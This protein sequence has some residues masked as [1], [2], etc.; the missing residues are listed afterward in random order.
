MRSTVYLVVLL[1]LIMMLAA[2][3]EKTTTQSV[4]SAP[5]ISPES[6]T[7]ESGTEVTITSTDEDVKIYYTINGSDPTNTSSLYSIPLYIPTIFAIG[8]NTGVVKARAYKDG[9]EPS[10]ITEVNYA[11]NYAEQVATPVITP[12]ADSLVIGNTVT[13]TCGTPGSQIRYTLDGSEPTISSLI[14]SVPVSIMKQGQV[15]VKAIAL[16]ASMNPSNVAGKTYT[17]TYEAPPMVAVPAGTL[18]FNNSVISISGF[19][20]APYEVSKV[21]YAAVMGETPSYFTNN[22]NAPVE[23]VSWFDTVEYCNRRSMQEG[24]EPCYSY[25]TYGTNPDDWPADWDKSKSNHELVTCNFAMNGYR[26]PTEMEWMYAANAA[27]ADTLATP[28]SGGSTVG[29]VAWYISNSGN[30]THVVGT[31]AA[32]AL[33]IYDLSGNVWEWCWDIYGSYPTGA[34]NNPSGP[35]AGSYRIF[36]GGSWH[37]S[38]PNCRIDTRNW[39]GAPVQYYDL[40]FRVVRK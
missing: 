36:R 40:G 7:Y 28:Y 35:A 21:G 19:F 20:M 18:N 17:V 25:S 37:S 11:T 31:K 2:C 14:Y 34:Q 8:A 16:R 1:A 9:Y 29:N 26:L 38:Y 33:G 22:I 15:T 27:A 39:G 10:P 6:G 13:I 3:E 32:N 5:V 23:R 12:A 24:L 30:A 4:L